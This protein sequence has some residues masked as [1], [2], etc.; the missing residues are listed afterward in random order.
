MTGP[1]TGSTT[2]R[3]GH[4]VTE[5]DR[6]WGAWMAAAQ[7]GDRSAYETLL[8][9]CIPFVKTVARQQGVAPDRIDDVV[10]DTLITIHR[11]RQTYD[12]RRSFTAWLRTIAQ[13]RA[14]D[15]LRR[16]GRR[17]ALEVYAPYAYENHPE[18]A[19][20]PAQTVDESVRAAA[21]NRAIATLPAGQ[22]EAVERIAMREQ[23]LAEAAAETGRST[24]ALKVNLHRAIKSL[25]LRLGKV[26]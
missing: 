16:H 26:D 18:S 23:S 5:L 6:Q 21:L 2:V 8:G 11:A 15:G 17:A 13:R 7:T 19:V 22:R 25:R 24:V 10:Q 12:P 4:R 3:E 9:A 20:D 1:T 14:I